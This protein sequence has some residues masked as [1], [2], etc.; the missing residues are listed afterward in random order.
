VD[1]SLKVYNSGTDD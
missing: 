1:H